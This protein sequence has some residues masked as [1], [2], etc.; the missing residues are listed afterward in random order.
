MKPL[1]PRQNLHYKPTITSG[2]KRPQSHIIHPTTQLNPAK[3]SRTTNTETEDN[4]PSDLGRRVLVV[5]G[6]RMQTN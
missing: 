1:K 2:C 5:L 4:Y 3:T 6:K